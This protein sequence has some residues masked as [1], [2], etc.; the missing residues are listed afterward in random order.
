MQTK[1]TADQIKGV[2]MEIEIPAQCVICDKHKSDLG[3]LLSIAESV[4]VNFQSF[5]PSLRVKLICTW[6]E[7]YKTDKRAEYINKAKRETSERIQ[8]FKEKNIK[9]FK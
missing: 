3:V 9:N 1:K 7:Q 5:E 8:K 6:F 2:N 4:G